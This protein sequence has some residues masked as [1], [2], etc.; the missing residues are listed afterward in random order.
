MRLLLIRHGATNNN[1]EGRYTGQSDIPLSRLGRL[2]AEA[3]AARVSSDAAS[4]V[5]ILVS[6]DLR[7]AKQ[8]A[9]A[10]A[11]RTGLDISEDADLREIS[12][13]RWEGLTYAEIEARYPEEL[14]RWQ[15][16]PL[17]VAPPEGETL[18]TFRER[19]VRALRR[20]R[21]L[22]PDKTVVWVTHGGA[23]GILLCEVLG[24]DLSHRWQFRRDNATIT[25]LDVGSD[26][27]ILMRTND[28][29]HLSDIAESEG[30]E[31]DQVL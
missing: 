6:S 12:M 25:E 30:R 19:L 9:H 31:V 4:P 28:G 1:L 14:A 17:H 3:V 27:V 18:I 8:T 22:A 5:D 7:R 10:I 29:A 24:L 26:Y 11:R 20:W 15:A 23:I 21:E 13:G 2:Q 16:D